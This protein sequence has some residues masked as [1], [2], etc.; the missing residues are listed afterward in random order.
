[1]DELSLEV[2]NLGLKVLYIFQRGLSLR[3]GLDCAPSDFVLAYFLN[4][5]D[6]LHHIR[7][8]VDSAFLDAKL[9]CRLL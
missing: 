8:V 5:T 2:T 6:A 3:L 1:M 7:Y 4:D 9:L